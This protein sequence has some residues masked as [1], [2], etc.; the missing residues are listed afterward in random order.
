MSD[1]EAVAGAR[2]AGGPLDGS[3]GGAKGEAPHATHTIYADAHDVPSGDQLATVAQFVETSF[4]GHPVEC[5]KR[6]TGESL[7]PTSDHAV[8][9]VEESS[10]LNRRAHELRWIGKWPRGGYRLFTESGTNINFPHG[11]Q[12]ADEKHAWCLWS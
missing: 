9:L 4:E 10:A 8:E 1:V 5:R 6:Q 7:K 12:H 11:S 3:H 2:I